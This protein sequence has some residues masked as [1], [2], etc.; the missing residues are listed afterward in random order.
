V[1]LVT[2]MLFQKRGKRL[3]VR[4]KE[5]KTRQ[6][7]K[8]FQSRSLLCYTRERVKREEKEILNANNTLLYTI[9]LPPSNHSSCSDV[10]SESYPMILHTTPP[11]FI[12]TTTPNHPTSQ[13]L[14]PLLY[15]TKLYRHPLAASFA[16]SNVSTLP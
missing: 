5:I 12:V 16:S 8:L 1:I 4:F 13:H 6:E 2:I 3:E 11:F 9:H 10:P 7:S 15:L 14:R